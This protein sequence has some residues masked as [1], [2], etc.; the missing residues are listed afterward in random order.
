MAVRSAD[1]VVV[2][3]GRMGAFQGRAWLVSLLPE[4]FDPQEMK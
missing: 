2:S 1:L 3:T 4:G